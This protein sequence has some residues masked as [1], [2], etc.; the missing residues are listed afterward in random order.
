MTTTLQY[1][2]YIWTSFEASSGAPTATT[3]TGLEPLPN[4]IYEPQMDEQNAELLDID[5]R[6]ARK[7]QRAVQ[8]LNFYL[9][10]KKK[11]EEKQK[12]NKKNMKSHSHKKVDGL[13]AENS[14]FEPHSGLMEN[15]I[16]SRIEKFG[17]TTD[18]KNI[19]ENTI[20]FVTA[21]SQCNSVK[22]FVPIALLYLKTN[23]RESIVAV[24][25]S[26]LSEFFGIKWESQT[27][28]AGSDELPDWLK[29]L[30]NLSNTWT[31]SLHAEGFGK[32][33]KLMSFCVALG[34]CQLSDIAP[35]VCGLQIFTLPPIKGSL[36]VVSV[37]DCIFDLVIHFA[38]GGYMCFKSGSLKP[39]LYG[40]Y[41]HQ[42]FS[43]MFHECLKC[44]Q[45]HTCGN[46]ELVNIDDNDLDKLFSD[47]LDLGKQL[48]SQCNNPA[49]QSIFDRQLEKLYLWQVDFQETRLSGGL[50]VAP[51][52]IGL[53]GN[54]AV[55]KS[56]LCPLIM[57]YVL[58]A[59]G[60]AADDHRIISIKETD[61]YMSNQRTHVNGIIFDDV[62]NTKAEFVQ[63][64]PTDTIIEIANN[65]RTYANM[66]EIS[67][68]A[69]VAIQPK[70]F[71]ITKNVKDS[72]ASVYSNCPASIARR[73]NITV[74][75]TVKEEYSNSGMICP[76]KIRAAFP[77][78]TPMYPDLWKLTVEQA[79]P[80][81]GAKGAQSSVGYAAVKSVSGK[82]LIDISLQEFI[83]YLRDASKDH[84]S[85][86]EQV[87]KA[88][89]KVG[90]RM[91]LCQECNAPVELCYC[92]PLEIEPI[93]QSDSSCSF[94]FKHSL[95]ETEEYDGEDEEDSGSLSEITSPNVTISSNFQKNVNFKD[96]Y[97][98]AGAPSQENEEDLLLDDIPDFYDKSAWKLVEKKSKFTP[99]SGE[100]PGFCEYWAR[101]GVNAAY[102]VVDMCSAVLQ[103]HFR[104]ALF[105]PL[106]LG[107]YV[108]AKTGKFFGKKF[109]KYVPL[110]FG[111]LS[112]LEKASTD[113][114]LDRLQQI[115]DSVYVHWTTWIPEW[116][117][118]SSTMREIIVETEWKKYSY[119]LRWSYFRC[120]LELFLIGPI[121]V[122]TH[123]YL[124]KRLKHWS[125]PVY[126]FAAIYAISRYEKIQ[127]L[128]E[129]EKERILE[130]ITMRRDLA[131]PLAKRIRDNHLTWIFG[132]S[133][134][135]ASVY[136]AVKTY[137]NMY[138]MFDVQ[139][140][141][142]PKTE[143]EV[144]ERDAEKCAWTPVVV[145]QRLS[146][147]STMSF[148][149]LARFAAANTAHLTFT[150]K[151][152]Q[153]HCNIFFTCSNVALI[154]KHMWIAD[155]LDALIVKREESVGSSFK[156]KI[157]R[158]FSVDIADNDLSLIWVPSGGDWK[159]LT[160]YFPVS[161]ITAVPARLYFRT[162]TGTMRVS[163]TF[164]APSNMS[165]PNITPYRGGRYVLEWP[166][167]PGMCMCP[168]VSEDRE[169]T[170]I[171]FHL[172]G[173]TD[174][175]NG[176]MGTLLRSTLLDA[177]ER[178][179]EISVV[180]LCKSSSLPDEA[181][182]GI[183]FYLG[184]EI[185]RKSAL[186]FLEPGASCEPI[187]PCIGMSTPRSIVMQSPISKEVAEI[188]GVPQQWGPPKMHEGYKWQESLA[189]SS[190]PSVGF[191]G[192]VLEKAFRS[193][194]E[195]TDRIGVGKM[196]Y[197]LEQTKP[198]SDVETISG[199]DGRRFI[200]AMK[201][202]TAIGY[203]FT[204]NK[205]KILY[206]VI[207][208]DHQAAQNVRDDFWK[209]FERVKESYRKGERTTQI[210]KACMKDEP[211]E[212]T[213]DKVRLF[214]AAP[215]VL[216]M[217]VRKYYLPIARLFSL[218]PTVSE[219]AV[220]INAESPEWEQL[221]DYI[222][223]KGENRILAGDYSKYDL[224]MPAQL[225]FAAFKILLNFARKCGYTDDDISI[226]EGF[227]T[228]VCYAYTAFNGDLIKFL[229]SNPS[230]QNLTVYIN[231][232][233]NSLIIRS[234]FYSF[235]TTAFAPRNFND[236]VAIVTYGDDIKGSVSY[237][238][239]S[240][241]HL[242]V[243]DFLSKHDMKFTMPDKDSKPQRFLKNSECDFLKR[244]T[245][246]NPDLNCRIGILGDSS[247]FK[248][249]H[250][251]MRS[252]FV[253]PKQIAAQNIDG[254]LRSW[255]FHGREV[256]EMRQLQMLE[257]AKRA[258]IAHMCAMLA[259][260]YEDLVIAW[261]LVH[262]KGKPHVQ[263]PLP[264][265][266]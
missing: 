187:G 55:G 131:A 123:V 52:T 49:Q 83:Y 226:M 98:F 184:G 116:A 115:E 16:C 48:K 119:K 21:C 159:D 177:I 4:S 225:M 92:C 233:V 87:V 133:V 100:I 166:T 2:R 217:G 121:T 14:R 211:T 236:N 118:E 7:N 56:T 43:D 35:T 256:Y 27:G 120:A 81:D 46:L 11:R 151:G 66:A 170:I 132:T 204:G 149:D 97:T 23:Y 221:D 95:P 104:Y 50:R 158:K 183:N 243:A 178:I 114:L 99:H 78:G 74:T 32:I 263:V 237:M 127:K 142:Y 242:V 36:S 191:E 139:G 165:L 138:G 112:R 28:V 85:N 262:G 206:P 174:T 198:L 197:L 190:R 160:R 96:W 34:M 251:Q 117:M 39:L 220:G 108:S 240:F 111:V 168:L 84:F 182:M 106:A 232:I 186:R 261:L 20:L 67:M 245:F 230:G 252:K 59:N 153:Y 161:H 1:F 222:I 188:C 72:G 77:E 228:E 64:S 193:Y 189:Y 82:P 241:N 51:Y 259:R 167:F 137:R 69:R 162:D 203:P 156:A 17:F 239:S 63:T 180:V 155:E 47:T 26:Y 144:D 60:F 79:Y 250:S 264:E 141:L 152:R 157:S 260:P 13:P 173:V 207:S 10:Y 258:E 143:G 266:N 257:V 136:V 150:A 93:V 192:D 163:T 94:G 33:A 227:A 199:I 265:G 201:T 234:A 147:G 12:K 124:P 209:E 75:V 38:E 213:K 146:N 101:R 109:K 210:F 42:R 154:P 44:H 202:N 22:Q 80:V 30:K 76:I 122:A 130:I 73:D 25:C 53:F 86:Q 19:V 185:H 200:D 254:A 194:T 40:S 110:C 89:T 113:V 8:F 179:K 102:R 145:Q 214:Q 31:L 238:C 231:S 253:T 229:G 215:M 37:V 140:N 223:S 45:L 90:E 105:P 103:N 135:V 91:I 128:V 244:K 24:A 61:K 126:A 3:P 235:Y 208:P 249:L 5:Q 196:A 246:Y 9:T 18:I 70:V 247:I 71:I 29:E 171:G 195:K 6:A 148:E 129:T 205:S 172:S 181:Q 125:Y 65:T 134:A 255:F 212:M 219:C 41:D 218:F 57:C 58:K 107:N 169:P 224:R 62:G 15:L 216:Q 176:C 164:V 175:P 68:K 88:A 54:T 248:S